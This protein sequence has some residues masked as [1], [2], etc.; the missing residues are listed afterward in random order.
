MF[1]TRGGQ[2]VKYVVKLPTTSSI[3]RARAS[4][5]LRSG[6]ITEPFIFALRSDDNAACTSAMAARFESNPIPF[7]EGTMLT[8]WDVAMNRAS[9]A[10]ISTS[11][12]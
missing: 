10:G 12:I 11:W 1:V 3:R 4:A 6:L 2:H 5:V 7:F 8:P 9:T